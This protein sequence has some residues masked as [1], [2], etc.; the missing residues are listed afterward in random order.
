MIGLL[1]GAASVL[2]AAWHG[3]A[4]VS[5]ERYFVFVSCPR[6]VPPH[7]TVSCKA[8]IR[9]DSGYSSAHDRITYEWTAA[10]DAGDALP[11]GAEFST[12]F[13]RTGDKEV[14]VKVCG[15]NTSP[16]EPTTEAADSPECYEASA[17][18]TVTEEAL[19]SSAGCSA[20]IVTVSDT[21]VC[22]VHYSFG[23]DSPFGY[24]RDIEWTAPANAKDATDTKSPR[25]ST[26][27]SGPGAATI[28]VRVCGHDR[29]SGIEVCD[30]RTFALDVNPLAR[31]TIH[32]LGCTDFVPVHELI[33]C[34][35]RITGQADLLFWVS[36]GGTPEQ[37]QGGR[38]STRHGEPG[39]KLI[40]LRA[41][42]G[43]D[44]PERCDW[45]TVYVRV[46]GPREPLIRTHGCM[47]ELVRIGD[48]IYCYPEVMGNITSWRWT[49][50]GGSRTEGDARDFATTFATPGAKSISLQACIGE[51]P[52]AECEMVGAAITVTA[53]A[54]LATPTVMVTTDKSSYQ[55]GDPIRICVEVNTAGVIRVFDLTPDGQRREV[56]TAQLAAHDC[57]TGMI[58]PPTGRECVHVEFTAAA[59]RMASAESCFEVRAAP[60]TTA[61]AAPAAQ[62]CPDWTGTWRS[63]AEP[64]LVLTQSGATLTG[65]FGYY[66][67][68]QVQIAGDTAT[69]AATT[70]QG[71]RIDLQIKLGWGT[72]GAGSL[73]R[74]V[75]CAY[76][77]VRIGAGGWTDFQR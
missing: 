4:L 48:W 49:A 5:A 76:M 66:G 27:F 17:P 46:T 12:R 61:M 69:G 2:A 24:T 54:S 35:P 59:G 15:L 3:A 7:V 21:V 45:G 71:R 56:R 29:D 28:T 34:S 64:D 11:N 37:G 60:P 43:A 50:P 74:F 62:G 39:V 23:V 36:V 33:V 8:S 55:V 44:E 73:T 67:Q 13:T 41:C 14:S 70:A 22:E 47:P 52:Y 19:I 57:F 10:P 53:P 6:S 30:S 63:R 26:G 38:F 31:P 42:T 77:A 32:S 65:T 18:V 20:A 68:A 1:V 40:G 51:D 16:D 58:T 25:F 9:A 75:A 72:D